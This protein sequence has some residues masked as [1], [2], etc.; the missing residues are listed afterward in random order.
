MNDPTP[1]PQNSRELDTALQQVM[2]SDRE[3]LRRLWLTIERRKIAEQALDQLESQFSRRYLASAQLRLRRQ[4]SVPGNITLPEHLPVSQRAD[5]IATAIAK[6]PVLILAGETG[7]GKTTQLP[8][9]CLQMGRGIDG[10]IGHTQP[11][12]IAASTVANRIA[13]EL[14]VVLGSCVGYQVRFSDQ[15]QAESQ[16]KL[17][18]DGILLAEIQRDP[19]LLKYDT[20]IIDEAHERS[21]NIDFLLG[22]IK[23]ILPKRPELRV[24]I[25]SATIDLER[26][27]KHFN[28]APILQ[29]SGRTF[30]VDIIYRPWM[31]EL[32]DQGQAI[33]EAVEE[34]LTLPRVSAG[35]ILVFLSGERDI[36]ETAQI[37]RKANLP[38]IEVLPLYARLSLAEQKRVFQ[39]HRGRRI[40]LATNVAETS[41]TVPGIGYV[42]DP[43]LARISR[44]SARTKVQRLP[45]EPVSQAS[46]NQRAG[47]CGRVSDGVCIRLYG[48]DDFLSR[49][50]FTDAEIQ[51]TNLASVVLQMLHLG[52]G[53]I[54]KFPFVDMP[55]RRYITDGYKLLE[56]LQAVDGQG[57]LTPM[58]KRL[59]S[60]SVDPRLARML[61]E[62]DKHRALSEV[63][64][65][66][67]ALAI[68]DPRERPADKQ[69]AADEQH[70]RFWH[71]QS[72]F[73]AYCN[74][75]QYVETQRQE[76][77]Q[78]HWRKQCQK[79]FLSF[80]RLREWRELHHQL[81]LACKQMGLKENTAPASPDSVHQSLLAGL[82]SLLGTRND[83]QSDLPYLGAR[84]RKFAIFPG[85]SLFKKKP[86][87]LMA[88]EMIETSKLF[89]HS[90]AKVEPGWILEAS[91]HLQKH[92]YHEPHYVV[93][94]GQVMGYD[95]ITLFGLVLTEKRPVNYSHIDKLAA[96]EVFIRS[97]LVEGGYG[98]N[99]RAKGR[100][101]KYNQD[102]IESL[103][104]LEAKSRRR[105]ILVD[106]E[107]IFQFYNERVDHSVCNLDGFEHWRKIAEKSHAD[108]LFMPR[109]LLMQHAAGDIS[110]AQFPDTLTVDGM[111]LPLSYHF[112]PGHPDDGVS[113][114]VPAAILHALPES[115]LDWLVPGFLRD[116]CIALIKSLPKQWRKLFVP[117]PHYV[118]Q[119]LSRLQP[120]NQPLLTAMTIELQRLLGRPLPD[121]LWNNVEPD[122][123][124]R[125][126]IHVLDE[127]HRIIDR[128]RDLGQLRERYREHV[129]STLQSAGEN[130][131][132]EHLTQ[133][134][135]GTLP[136][137]QYLE[138]HGI[139]VK[140]FPSLVAEKD[141]IALRMLANPDDALT[142]SRMGMVRLIQLQLNQA[143]K[144]LHKN[145]IRNKDIGLALVNL[146]KREQVIQDI[147]DAAV[148][149]GAR[150]DEP[151]PREQ[152][153]FDDRVKWVAQS[154]LPIAQQYE[155]ILLDVLKQVVLVRNALKNGRNTLT[156]A[157]AFAD[158]KAQ[159]DRLFYPGCLYDTRLQWF[160][161]YPR[162]LKAIQ[163]RLE[164]A[165]LDVRKDKLQ[166]DKV[167]EFWQ[168]HED[169]LQKEGE[170][171]YQ[172]NAQWQ[173]YR[174]LIEEY[175]VSLFA[176]T[177]KTML[178]VS[179][180]RL[181][182]L[183]QDSLS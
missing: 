137:T 180:K 18:T 150:L 63:L 167:A 44:Y 8:K 13:E 105:D 96:R 160:E 134:D 92:H 148:Y 175:R 156:L 166:L 155:T 73:L 6:Y 25:T 102:T 126:N 138:Q 46:A 151:I 140:A 43:G 62:A 141:S 106:D 72:D 125:L 91:G 95:R 15:S 31:G 142:Q 178:P 165:P 86:K 52:I 154:L 168:R 176:Q 11:R 4:E 54:R 74:L 153:Q 22:Y 42:I 163:V 49:P 17:M 20:L 45:I 48:E 19:L 121:D 173:Q 115:R 88:A 143:V 75:W 14:G 28:N 40:V 111:V 83:E 110:V 90:I 159:L 34:I 29:V 84:N 27:A 24:I 32:E 38:H 47:R 112:E 79:E 157:F 131:E 26:F 60:L 36:R 101:F 179:D 169:R 99:P 65:I 104:L 51:R 30:P 50:A 68:Q 161:Q 144:Y 76:L 132:C 7:S 122:D 98:K 5:E 152:N 108:L 78:N 170:Q 23:K 164:K 103:H 1:I 158:I 12:R 139:K 107:V 89:A 145:L 82:L 3:P 120:S 147:I 119:I 117:V 113:I 127:H 67:A 37:L 118:D 41:I 85:S 174:W 55:D 114:G 146:G 183:W 39:A 109:E 33:L 94:T 35:D 93:K 130:L 77:S 59:A 69:Q 135:F 58:G 181:L 80:L 128:G 81:R 16:I 97:A 116:K 124:Y 61:I 9:I 123:F 64:V 2:L 129:Q 177:L 10:T 71:E 57:R 53:D 21:L 172:N 56:E 70:R 87:W 162:Y 136:E 66:V 182:K 171:A 133:W 149:H 100:F